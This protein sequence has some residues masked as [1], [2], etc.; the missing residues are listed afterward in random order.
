MAEPFLKFELQGGQQLARVLEVLKDANSRRKQ[1]KML[2]D[3]AE[4][5]RAAMATN[6]PR[7]EGTHGRHL[8]DSM[9]ISSVR[10]LQGGL[11]NDPTVSVGPSKEAFWGFFQEVGTISHSPS[12]FA[13]TAFEATT[14]AAFAIIQDRTWE[15]IR[16]AIQRGG[17]RA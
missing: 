4:P 6:A 11:E 10:G 12:P 13:G 16:K 1:F 5:I 8:A 17:G 2:R 14:G 9:V 15:L 7:G 3:A